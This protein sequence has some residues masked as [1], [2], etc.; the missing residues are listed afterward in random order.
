MAISI[1]L[2]SHNKNFLNTALQQ[3]NNNGETAIAKEMYGK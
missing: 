3:S 1:L 2:S